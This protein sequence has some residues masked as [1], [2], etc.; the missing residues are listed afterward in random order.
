[1]EVKISQAEKA[2]E[3]IRDEILTQK[4]TPGT[5]IIESDYGAQI[6]M[7]RTPVREALKRLANEGFIEIIPRKGA[8]VKNYSIKDMLM[9][10]E[11][12]EVIDGALAANL[13]LAHKN[14]EIED[15][16]ISYLNALVDDMDKA[17][18]QKDM[19]V[20]AK[21]DMNFHICLCEMCKNPYISTYATQIRVQLSRVL[22]F[23]TPKYI[24]KQMS[25]NE[26]RELVKAIDSGDCERARII[27]GE[28]SR[29]IRKEL[30]DLI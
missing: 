2:Y 29:R 8:I 17:F 7:S 24:D 25:N 18:E 19:K 20:W 13:A 28:Q 12:A 10:H 30:I 11:I 22:W 1:M 15:E 5:L 14:G 3:I 4:L 9:C 16:K 6:E 26:H 23:I 21:S 27:A